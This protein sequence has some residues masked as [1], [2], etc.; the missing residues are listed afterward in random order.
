MNLKQQLHNLFKDE[1]IYYNTSKL[2]NR[3]LALVSTYVDEVLE[4]GKDSWTA[5]EQLEKQRKRKQELL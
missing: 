5:E 1:D 3:I 4:A 2:E